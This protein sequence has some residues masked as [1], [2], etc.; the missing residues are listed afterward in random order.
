M[1]IITLHCRCKKIIKKSHKG[2]I[3]NDY[4]YCTVILFSSK[5]NSFLERFL[6]WHLITIRHGINFLSILYIDTIRIEDR[7]R[8][9]PL[10]SGS[11]ITLHC[12]KYI[13]LVYV[14]TIQNV[15]QW[16]CKICKY[17]YSIDW[18]G[19]KHSSLVFVCS[20][21]TFQVMIVGL[22]VRKTCVKLNYP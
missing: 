19:S 10:Y 22:Q 2:H 5:Y 12:E 6:Y 18:Q 8:V 20:I 3:I 15:V 16:T 7:N 14:L 1:Y 17:T 13:P 11:I 9:R 4:N 21:K